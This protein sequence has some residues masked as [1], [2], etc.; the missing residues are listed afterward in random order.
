MPYHSFIG[1]VTTNGDNYEK[2]PD[3][4]TSLNNAVQQ[5]RE[6]KF[7]NEPMELPAEAVEAPKTNTIVS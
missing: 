3:V 7:V 6:I 4:R 5:I 1:T 2:A